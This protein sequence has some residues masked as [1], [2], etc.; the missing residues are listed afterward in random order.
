MEDSQMQTQNKFAKLAG[1]VIMGSLLLSLNT[2]A[3]AESDAAKAIRASSATIPTNI[4][5]IHTYAEPPKGF[6]PL[7][8]S[9][10]DLATYGF[11]PRPN[12]ETHPADYTMWE[13]AVKAAKIRWNGE[14]KP[15]LGI[16]HEMSQ[17]R[18][19]SL[20]E[21]AQA[22]A[23]GP[24]QI[25]TNNAAGVVL[26]N[27]QTA[28]SNTNSFSDVVAE[29][30][31]AKAQLPFGSI[32]C[33]SSNYDEVSYVGI[34]G[35]VAGGDFGYPIVQAG[36]YA[37]VN[38]PAPGVS[39]YAVIGVEADLQ[40]EFQVN[41][42]DVV[43]EQIIVNGGTGTVS[44]VLL[45]I[46]TSVYGSYSFSVSGIVGNS[47]DF[48]VGRLCCTSNDLPYQLANTTQ[49]TFNGAM[50]ETGNST[51][52]Y[53]GSQASSTEILTMT[54]AGDIEVVSG[55]GSSG[56]QGEHSLWFTTTGCAWEYGCNQ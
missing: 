37:D 34:D 30:T 43:Y 2:L 1:L 44:V 18:S 22:Q 15:L 20:P 40:A 4:P 53:P 21:A 19:L 12:E 5:G 55:Q 11:P 54:D 41:P 56:Y 52:F 47:A 50:A 28:W 24:Q 46:T 39:Y 14:L 13:R 38:C 33:T 42:G 23:S 17:V 25:S 16:G 26:T 27:T 35:F 36:V 6:N 8:A 7:A 51:V 48:I 49:I 32:S 3:T 31:V 9:E 10:A 45:D 29:V